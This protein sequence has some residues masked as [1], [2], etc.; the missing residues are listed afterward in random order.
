MVEMM[1]GMMVIGVLLQLP[2]IAPGR[3]LQNPVPASAA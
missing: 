3:Y 2:M 1:V